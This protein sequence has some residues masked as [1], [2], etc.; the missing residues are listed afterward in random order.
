MIITVTQSLVSW[1]QEAFDGNQEHLQI[2]GQQGILVYWAQYLKNLKMT[3]NTKI[4]LFDNKFLLVD[5]RRYLVTCNII[6]G[7]K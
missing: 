1:K 2:K 6:K 4:Y 7:L 5:I 3:F